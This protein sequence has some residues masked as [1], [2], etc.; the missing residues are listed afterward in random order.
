MRIQIGTRVKFLNDVGGGIVRGF[1]DDRYAMVENNDGFEIPVLLNELLIDEASGYSDDGTQLPAPKPVVQDKQAVK[2]SYEKSK[3]LQFKGN[4][5]LAIVPQNDQLMHVTDFNLYLVNDSNYTFVYQ[6][7]QDDASTLKLLDSGEVE[8]DTKT[9]IG[10]YSQSALSKLRGIRLQGFYY[11]TGLFDPQP[12]I[13]QVFDL[14]GLSVYKANLFGE[15][16]FFH[17]KAFIL[18]DELAQRAEEERI[19]QEAKKMLR[20]K[21]ATQVKTQHKSPKNDSIEEVDLHIEEIVE[22]SAGMSNGEIIRTQMA[23]F[24]TALETAMRSKTQKIVFIHGVGN[25]RLRQELRKTLDRKYTELRYQDAS[26]MEYGYGAT[27]VYL[28]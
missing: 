2:A 5:C 18:R 1:S 6:V 26:F 21:E 14:S 8:A 3:F 4:I 15:N 10:E 9:E 19:K 17:Q 12:V 13:D 25:G 7:S 23:R 20:E 11:K 28:K 16:E 24:E 22:N 27:M